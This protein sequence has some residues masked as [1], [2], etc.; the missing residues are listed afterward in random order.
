MKH[1]YAYTLFASSLLAACSGDDGN[2]RVVGE[3][4]S[5]RIEVTADYAEAIT[6]IAVAEGARVTAGDLLL[7]QD[8]ARALAQL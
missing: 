2:H 4:A 1:L 6:Q 8:N 7:T 5:D 3:L